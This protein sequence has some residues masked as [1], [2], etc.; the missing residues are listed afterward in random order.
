MPKEIEAKFK[1]ATFAAVRRALRLAGAK[2]LGCAIQ[3]DRYF[4]TASRV[5]LKADSG[6]RMRLSKPPKTGA[7]G[8]S[9]RD[10]HVLLTFKGPAK[11]GS[12]AK[13]RSEFQ[14]RLAD[15]AAV[16]AVFAQ[17]GLKPVLTIQKRRESFR[18][19]KTLIEL[20]ELPLIGRFVEIEAAGEKTID[21]VRR[22]LA[23]PDK[24]INDHY[25][26]LLLAACRRVNKTCGEISFNACRDCLAIR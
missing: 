19:G 15:P 13:I 1:V 25:V 14:V 2:R 12:R 24:P 23:L 4:D 22:M 5:L 10:S 17:C 6:V 20:D 18:L 3:T 16:E 11:K 8:R 26:N 9:C 7:S 21:K